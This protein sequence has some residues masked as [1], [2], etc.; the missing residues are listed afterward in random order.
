M[1]SVSSDVSSLSAATF[2]WL[3]LPIHLAI[4]LV[5]GLATAAIVLFVRRT[6]PDLLE[7]ASAPRR[8]LAPALAGFAAAALLTGGLLSWF[9]SGDPDGLEWSLAGA[10][11]AAELPAPD[12]PVHR[13][14]A[15]AQERAALLPDY[16]LPGVRAGDAGA[17]A[18]VVN[19]GTSLSGVVGGI[20]TLLLLLGAGWL[21]KRR[22]R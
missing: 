21:L 13:A 2:L 8:L 3:M 6:R 1:R 5:E 17:P 11:P 19:P 16:D 22:R 20:A 18:S 10:A 12:T 9:A 14:L 4:G 15:Q 7:R